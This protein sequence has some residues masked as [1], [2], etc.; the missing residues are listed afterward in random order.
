MNSSAQT[1]SWLPGYHRED[2]ALITRIGEH[3]CR[4]QAEEG[5]GDARVRE[6]GQPGGIQRRSAGS[7]HRRH[8]R[9][10]GLPAAG[11]P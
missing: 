5:A 7:H 6:P 11:P 9:R 1:V 8:P 4:W 3:R 10:G 2:D